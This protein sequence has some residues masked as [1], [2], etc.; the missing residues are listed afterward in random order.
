VNLK[1]YTYSLATLAGLAVLMIV[2]IAWATGTPSVP[3]FS[4]YTNVKARK[5]AFFGYFRPL[6][7][8]HNQSISVTRERIQTWYKHREDLSWFA[9]RRLEKLARNYGLAK[10][11]VNSEKHWGRLLKRV[12]IV[13]TSLALAQAAVESAWGTSRFARKVNNYFG[14]WCF[15]KDCG[16]VPNNRDPDAR[17][18]VKGFESPENAVASYVH[19]L[20]THYAYNSFRELR[21]QLRAEDKPLSGM[22]LANGLKHYSERGVVYTKELRDLIKKNKLSQY[23]NENI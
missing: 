15:S 13:P 7:D 9:H 17:H 1:K 3:D 20:N 23:D 16:L 19:N 2:I 12:D 22:V 6:I 21:A 18:E 8:E 5:T 11:D 10:F 4:Q 14:Q